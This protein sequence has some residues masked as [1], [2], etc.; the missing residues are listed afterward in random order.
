[1]IFHLTGLTSIWRVAV[2][3][4]LAAGLFT[5]GACTEKETPQAAVRKFMFW[6]PA[7]DEPRIQFLRTISSSK[8]I[9]GGQSQMDELVYGKGEDRT[10]PLIRP[11]GVKWYSGKA[12]VCDAT[13]G[14]VAVLDIR[15]KQVAVLGGGAQPSLFKPI[16]IVVSPEQIKYVA[17]TGYSAVI[18]LDQNNKVAGRITAPNMRPISVALRGDELYVSD[19]QSS[20]V[21]VFDRFN[22]K[23]LRAI[24]E[25]G[26]GE[27]KLAG[28]MGLTLDAAGN[29]YVNDVVG[30]KV[31]KF[32]P[33]GKLLKSWGG[34]GTT[35]GK[36][37]RPKMM[38]VDSDGIVYV[39]DNAF[40]NVQ[41]F[42]ADGDTLM[43][44]GGAGPF[45]GA[46]DMPT[47]VA[48]VETDLDLF[49]PYVHDAFEMRRVLI[50][51]NNFGWRK[52]N[53]YAMGQL[54][55]GKTVADL[56]ATRLEDKSVFDSSS[57]TSGS[58][59]QPGRT[60]QLQPTEDP[61]LQESTT[62]PK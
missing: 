18:V 25:Q 40:Q 17:D 1:M 50:V 12:Y 48:V 15:G 59:T 6:P 10:L 54:R 9:T 29:I 35:T 21:R 39:V 31:Q 22:G 27:G 28:A 33:E 46:M 19:M 43:Y 41:M 55:P 23:Q 2:A 38:A 56:S 24:G 37:V 53:F 8:E 11:Y 32:S 20:V 62:K 60:L 30:C 57:I 5:L 34:R 52:V 14:I 44:F 4:V 36:F 3:G 61:A 26:G 51:T 49:A 16:D 58:S 7:P 13:A 45:A 47:G 42:N